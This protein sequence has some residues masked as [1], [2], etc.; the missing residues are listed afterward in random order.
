MNEKWRNFRCDST[1]K[2][3]EFTAITVELCIAAS[4]RTCVRMCNDDSGCVQKYALVF[5]KCK[6]K[7]SI[8]CDARYLHLICV[9]MHH[10]SAL[11]ASPKRSPIPKRH[12]LSCLILEY[13]CCF[14]FFRVVCSFFFLFIYTNPLSNFLCSQRAKQASVWFFYSRSPLNGWWKSFLEF[15]LSLCLSSSLPNYIHVCTIYIYKC[16]YIHK[17][18]VI[19]RKT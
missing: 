16:V 8:R 6:L 1:S 17:A 19:M 11:V 2:R 9:W 3:F 7:S 18:I 10:L 12:W 13:L 5:K 15:L 4:W 14:G